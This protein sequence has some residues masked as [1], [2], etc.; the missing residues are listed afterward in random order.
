MNKSKI[1]PS[2]TASETAERDCVVLEHLPLVEAIALRVRAKLP[3]CAD[4]DDLINAG[5]LGLF[6]AAGKYRPD[7]EV[8]F[9]SYAKHRIKGAMLDS[10]RRLDWAS[11]DIRRRRKQVEAVFLELSYT[12]QRYPTDDE[13]AE[14]LNVTM[15]E[16]HKIRKD[17][18]DV[19]VVSTSPRQSDSE[20]AAPDLPC[21]TE[22]HPDNIC[23]NKQMRT[24]VRS[25]VLSLPE[26]YQ[27]VIHFYYSD[28]MTMKEIGSRLG[29]NE[30]R[31]SQLHKL[32]LVKM[33]VSLQSNGIHSGNAL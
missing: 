15:Q 18:H 33:H 1:T 7:K 16:W 25:A 17:V 12:L 32:A 13:V 21:N 24:L 5:V 28:G 22:N 19:G 20:L 27:K 26:R 2:V 29:V 3:A 30:S 14:T 4:L 31:V 23:A 9:R 8:P 11:R 6:E 10:L